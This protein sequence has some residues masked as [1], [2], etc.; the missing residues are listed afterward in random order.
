MR[1]ESNIKKFYIYRI[2][3]SFTFFLPVYYL[4]LLEKGLNLTEVLI[5]QAVFSMTIVLSQVPS[6]AFA[7]IVGKKYALALSNFLYLISLIL[8]TFAQSFWTLVFTEILWGIATALW[9]SSGSS[10]IF[11]TLKNLKKE[12]QFKKI[13]G[14]AYAITLSLW[15]ICSLAGGYIGAFYGLSWTLY[16]SLPTIF[17]SMFIPLLF[18]E[19]NVKEKRT[20]SQYF[21]QIKDS[22]KFASTHKMLRL[23]LLYSSIVV[24]VLMISFPVSQPYLVEKGLP[25]QLLGWFFLIGSGIGAIGAKLAHKIEP[26]IGYKRSLYYVMVIPLVFFFVLFITKNLILS[27]ISLWIVSIVEPFSFPIINNYVNTHSVPN[28]RATLL[29]LRHFGQNLVFA[30]SA[31]LLGLFGDHF[32]TISHIYLGISIIFIP[33]T[34]IFFLVLRKKALR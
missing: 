23:Y 15:G 24:G 33:I 3:S 21:G 20:L 32:G 13:D 17:I 8:I 18:K 10:F 1:I 29:S 22:I 28:E 11:D 27:I 31:P 7:D 25:I 4:F 16:L 34:I 12:K 30:L 14:T 2:F 19:P 9:L 5:V 26:L 6:G